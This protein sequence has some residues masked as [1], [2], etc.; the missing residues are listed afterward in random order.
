[1][2]GLSRDARERGGGDREGCERDDQDKVDQRNGHAR[3]QLTPTLSLSVLTHSQY[4]NLCAIGLSRVP[5]ER[6]GGD[7][8]R[9]GCEGDDQDEVDQRHGQAR[10]QHGTADGRRL[11]SELRVCQARCM[12][13]LLHVLEQHDIGAFVVVIEDP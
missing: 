7:R 12:P 2:I 8:D 3:T 9:E 13:R 10:A 5:R 1:M 11:R 6:G 4:L